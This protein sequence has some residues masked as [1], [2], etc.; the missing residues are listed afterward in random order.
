MYHPHLQLTALLAWVSVVACWDLSVR[1]SSVNYTQLAEKLSKSAQI[2]LPGSSGFNADVARWSNLSTPVA[3][4]VVV[5]SNEQDIV[6]TVSALRPLSLPY[7]FAYHSS[8]G[9]D[10]LRKPELA[11]FSH[12]QWR[13]WIH[14]HAG[15]NDAWHRNPYEPAE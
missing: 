3:S 6:E 5:P 1:S 11:T 9:L 13:A 2:Y 7:Q 15:E 8:H 4:V 14:H 12:H 10:S